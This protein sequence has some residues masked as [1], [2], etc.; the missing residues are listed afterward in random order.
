M[1]KKDFLSKENTNIAR[2]VAILMILICHVVAIVLPARYGRLLTPFGGIGVAV[3][4]VISGYGSNESYLNRGLHNFWKKKICVVILPY[5]VAF[6][7]H[8]LL[9][10][11]FLNP[12][13]LIKEFFAIESSYY[14]Y[15]WYQFVWYAA[16]YISVRFKNNM[17]FKYM[18]LGVAAICSFVFL[19]AIRAEQSFSFLLGVLLSDFK[20]LK[21]KMQSIYVAIVALFLGI[22]SLALKQ[23]SVIRDMGG[24]L[25]NFV[26]LCI[27]LP[28]GIF[29]LLV[30]GCMMSIS[31][32]QVLKK[33]LN[34]MGN[35]SYP[36]YLAHTACIIL[37]ILIAPRLLGFVVF[38]VVTVALA[39][40]LD[41]VSKQFNKCIRK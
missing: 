6:L 19:D 39:I 4:L 36:L 7:I 9:N 8:A 16:F 10:G 24:I 1:Q 2:G 34:V 37:I 11:L 22:G 31:I 18:I 41:F 17:A 40:L 14:W 15:I 21:Q 29:V 3:F 23:V 28:L 12:V 38:L 25:M 20:E 5:I 33:P 26:Q 35:L 30:V 27:K 13:S 32:P